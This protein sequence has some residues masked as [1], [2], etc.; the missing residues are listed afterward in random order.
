MKKSLDQDINV[1][2]DIRRSLLNFIFDT[3]SLFYASSIQ[4]VQRILGWKR[5][6]GFDV[7]K[8]YQQAAGLTI[9][10]IE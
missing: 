3:C 6:C 7:T 10:I 5:I 9:I 1:T 2:G 4:P 8:C